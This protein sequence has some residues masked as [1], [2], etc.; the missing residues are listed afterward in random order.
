MGTVPDRTAASTG[1]R[2]SAVRDGSPGLLP[3]PPDARPGLFPA[4]GPRRRADTEAM[5]RY[6]VILGF[7]AAVARVGLTANTPTEAVCLDGMFD[8]DGNRPL[9]VS[10]QPRG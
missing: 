1:I 7:G 9:T 3:R 10:A 5:R 4:Y 6:F 2:R 8:A